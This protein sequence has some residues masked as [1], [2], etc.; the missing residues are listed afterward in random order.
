MYGYVELEFL[1]ALFKKIQKKKNNNKKI[2]AKIGLLSH[3]P[4]AMTQ[5]N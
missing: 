4:A 5:S 1:Y 3:M 2:P